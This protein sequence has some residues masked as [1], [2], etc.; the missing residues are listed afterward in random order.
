ML[1]ET[2][3]LAIG[4]RPSRHKSKAIAEDLNLGLAVGEL[5]CLLGPNGAGKSTLL[6]TLAGMQQPLSGEV[7]LD[8]TNI[9]RLSPLEIARRM[10]VV[11]T[12]RVDIGALSGYGLV[13]LG[14]HPYTGW[15]GNL[16]AH[17]EDIIHRA[18]R[19]VDAESLAV[20]PFA[21]L[22]DG[23]KQKLLIARALAQEPRLMIL[24]EPTAFLDLP[25]RVEILQ[26]LR[27]LAHQHR[28]TILLSTHDLDLALRCAD[29]IWLMPR[30]G[31]V[32]SGAPEDL[33][34][35]GSF[36][37]TF[38]AEGVQFDKTTGAFRLRTDTQHALYIEADP[39]A[40][41]WLRRALER[42]GFSIAQKNEPSTGSIIAQSHAEGMDW[43]VRI[44]NEEIACDKIEAVIQ[45][46][47]EHIF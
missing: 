24:D 36:E 35:D 45:A 26:L 42:S 3:K 40:A 41:L 17:D 22:S 14:R 31:G 39:E 20:R 13:A 30:D 23:E 19:A 34:L 8:S 47:Q 29:R 1:L 5:V 15:S 12:E 16:S 11:L 21:E 44:G 10:S 37:A 7:L 6:R 46:L 27:R 32:L 43:L 9:H 2:R 28:Q 33:V 4:Y 25:R 38:N 18:V